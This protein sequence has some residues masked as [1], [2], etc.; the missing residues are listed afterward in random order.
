MRPK[1]KSSEISIYCSL[2]P[3]LDL[4]PKNF[5]VF[6]GED[7]FTNSLERGSHIFT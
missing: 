3:N 6:D 2:K 4:L 7:D 1:R 5:T